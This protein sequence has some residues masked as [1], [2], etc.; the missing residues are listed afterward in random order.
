[1]AYATIGW[2]GEALPPGGQ[3]DLPTA[4]PENRMFTEFLGDNVGL[5]V[6]MLTH[7]LMRSLWGASQEKKLEGF[8]RIMDYAASYDIWT[9]PNG[10]EQL[11][12]MN[13]RMP[14]GRGEH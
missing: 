3:S 5:D 4:L 7:T 11:E 2:H 14:V 1:M 9:R 8:R 12:L 10:T 6:D 13:R